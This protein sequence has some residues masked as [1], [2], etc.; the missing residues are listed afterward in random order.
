MAASDWLRHSLRAKVT[1]GLLVPLGL[2]LGVFTLVE[3]TRLRTAMYANVS[4]VAAQ[5]GQVIESSLRHAMLARDPTG[6]QHM[7]DAIGESETL[8]AVYLLDP[9]G[10]VVFA[11]QQAQVG[12]RFDNQDPTCQPCHTVPVEQRPRSIVVTRPDGQRIF[13]SMT[14]I[15]NEP[16]C[17]SCHDSSERLVGLLLTDVSVTHFEAPMLTDLRENLLWWA[18]VIL[19]TVLVVNLVINRLVLGRLKKVTH[20]LARFGH[21]QLGLRLPIGAPDEIGQVAQAFNAMGSRLQAEEDENRRLAA[22]RQEL[23]QRLMTVQ[24]DERRRIARDLHDDL[25][26]DLAGLSLGLEALERLAATQPQALPD[27][28][29]RLRSQTALATEELYDLILSL[30]PSVLDD[31]GLPAGVRSLAERLLSGPGIEY[32][33]KATELSQR[34]PAEME[35][36]LFRVIQEALHN[37][38]RHARARHVDI[39]LTAQAGAFE[40]EVIDDGVGFDPASVQANGHSPHGLGLLGMRERVAQLAGR[41]E[42]VS[43]PGAGTRLRIWVPLPEVTYG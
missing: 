29:A 15:Q 21:G 42:V 43:Q 33:I 32:Q 14:P 1:L 16:E 10:Q 23:L 36:A 39:V 5:T 37:I 27:H 30:R 24:E 11:P 18:A 40:G 25:G 34:L 35:T 41:L 26:Q 13:R 20:S 3:H 22:G 6:L 31:L 12:V 38:V 2:I 4:G 8:S 9:R 19:A 7:L 17:Q 28:V